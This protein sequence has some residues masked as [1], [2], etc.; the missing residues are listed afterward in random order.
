MS[1]C[2]LSIWDSSIL[3]EQVKKYNQFAQPFKKSDS[4]KTHPSKFYYEIPFCLK[5]GLGPDWFLENS[6]NRWFCNFLV[7]HRMIRFVKR[8]KSVAWNKHHYYWKL[9]NRKWNIE[10]YG[11][12]VSWNHLKYIGKSFT[13]Q[14]CREIS[15]WHQNFSSIQ[16]FITC[17]NCSVIEKRLILFFLR[18]RLAIFQDNDSVT[19]IIKLSP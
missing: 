6:S 13:S 2:S 7:L 14:T 9:S 15:F 12:N 19:N 8:Q 10:F 1:T 16:N 4:W 18:S 17:K 11:V 3:I 5:S